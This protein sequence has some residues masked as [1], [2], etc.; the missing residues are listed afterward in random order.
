MNRTNIVHHRWSR[1]WTA[2]VFIGAV[3]LVTASLLYTVNLIGRLEEEPRIMS[4]LFARY[5]MTA[6][7][8]ETAGGSPETEIIFEEVI[9]KINFPVIVTDKK[10]LPLAWKGVGVESFPVTAR[11]QRRWDSL[12]ADDPLY[13]IKLALQRI[14]Q[15]N[16]PIPMM[17]GPDSTIVGYVHYGH[18]AILRELHYVPLIQI[19]VIALFVWIGFIGF[20]AIRLKEE[21]AVWVGLAKEAAHQLGTPAS[22]LLGWLTLLREGTKPLPEVIPEMEAD[23]AHI[24]KVLGRFNQIGSAIRLQRQPLNPVIDEAVSYFEHRLLTLGKKVQFVREYDR[25]CTVNV[26]RDLLIWAFE[27]L[28]KNAMDAIDHDRGRIAV[29]TRALE[30]RVEISYEDNGR[31]IA[32]KHQRKIFSTGFTTKAVGWGLGLPLVRRI[33]EEYHDGRVRLA[34]SKPGQGSTFVIS[35]PLSE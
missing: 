23:L 18:P 32:P 29:R 33:V 13:G 30:K 35:L 12:A 15:Q 14:D 31:G 2:Y 9:Q 5:C 16:R 3:V 26:N 24:E 25:D 10:G 34:S 27:N 21:R 28:I 20:R 7:M 17:L 8:P 6:A 4:R 22:S 11:E 19:G 1:V